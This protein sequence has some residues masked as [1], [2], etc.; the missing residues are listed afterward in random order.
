MNGETQLTGNPGVGSFVQAVV[1]LFPDSMPL[2]RITAVLN[3]PKPLEFMD[4]VKAIDW[5]WWTIGAA[6]V[7]VTGDTQ[8]SGNP[9]VGDRVFVKAVQQPSGEIWATS[10][11]VQQ[12]DRGADRR[13]D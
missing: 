10:I 9:K 5:P 6:Q 4:Y 13:H 3:P 12:C 1:W 7:K 2:A 8:I 11:T